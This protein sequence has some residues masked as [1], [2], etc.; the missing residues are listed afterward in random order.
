M[1]LPRHGLAA[2]IL[3][4][5]T[6]LLCG[7]AGYG[8]DNRMLGNTREQVVQAL[9]T[10][11]T[12]LTT[13]DG[14]VMMYPRGP[15]AKHTYFVY[16][17]RDGNMERWTQVL[18]EKNFAQIKPNMHRDEVVALIG[19]SKA[20]FGIARNRGYVWNYRYVTPLCFWF[21]IEFTR[22]DTVRSTGYSQPPE[23]RIRGSR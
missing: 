2:T 22:E 17:N 14:R 6:L 12:E 13:P 16:L 20:T 11:T 18:D 8:P 15:F 10:P 3:L 5:A 21:Q 7:C 19:V 4:T 9:G 23:C 1:I